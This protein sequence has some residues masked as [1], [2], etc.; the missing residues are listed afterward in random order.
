MFGDG[1]GAND[2]SGVTAAETAEVE[3]PTELAAV[4]VAVYATPFVRPVTTC[5]K[6][7]GLIPPVTCEPGLTVTV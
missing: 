4:T 6:V 1:R 3:E 2:A 5:V 7:L